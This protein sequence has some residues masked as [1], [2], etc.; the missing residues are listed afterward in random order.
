MVRFDD[1]ISEIVFL[2]SWL[3][4]TIFSFRGFEG[5]MDSDEESELDED[6]KFSS[7]SEPS[8]WLLSTLRSLIGLATPN[9]I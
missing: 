8:L 3:N 1:L 7:P 4:F 5:D 6:E 9:V 2:D